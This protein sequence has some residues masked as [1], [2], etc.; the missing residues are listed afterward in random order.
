[1]KNSLSPPKNLI[2]LQ[3]EK[4]K[5]YL[6]ST[7]ENIEIWS[8]IFSSKRKFSI[9]N[10]EGSFFDREFKKNKNRQLN[11]FRIGKDK[12]FVEVLCFWA[13]YQGNFEF[14]IYEKFGENIS[15]K[16]LLLREFSLDKNGSIKEANKK[17]VAALSRFDPINQTL[18]LIAKS[19][20][21]GGCG[22]LARYKYDDDK[23]NL[24]LFRAQFEC[25][26]RKGYN[27]DQ[28]PIIYPWQK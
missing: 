8:F 26:R 14:F 13:N 22:F 15:L 16:P 1:M 21:S 7:Q 23:L 19:R 6:P 11:V 3:K 20:G 2:E 12:F 17:S 5:E 9:C 25:V 27:P 28:Y 18:E 24:L 4:F 10:H